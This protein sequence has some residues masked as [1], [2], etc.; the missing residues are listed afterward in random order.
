MIKVDCKECKH[1]MEIFVESEDIIYTIDAPVYF[2]FQ[3][4]VICENCG[5][6]INVYER[7]I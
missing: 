1:V 7:K 3:K 2:I 6:E 5:S 4:T